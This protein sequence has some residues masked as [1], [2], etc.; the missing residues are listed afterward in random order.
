[1]LGDSPAVT[2]NCVGNGSVY[3]IGGYS[4]DATIHVLLGRLHN[5][6][7]IPCPFTAP[8][9]VEIVVRKGRRHTYVI[10]LNHSPTTQHVSE[11]VSERR[12]QA[13]LVLRPFD[14]T[15]VRLRR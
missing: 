3:Y 15:V 14:V 5:E 4:P 6:L 7:K 12:I 8:S 1:V 9:E 13:D 2:C 10:A 11:L